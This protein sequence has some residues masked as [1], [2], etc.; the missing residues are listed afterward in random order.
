[1]Y[2]C[3]FVYGYICICVHICVPLLIGEIRLLPRYG[4][5]VSIAPHQDVIVVGGLV[6]Y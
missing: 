5:P 4:Q 6:A 1:M 3:I 2:V